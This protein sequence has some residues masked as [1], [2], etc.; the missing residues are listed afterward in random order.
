MPTRTVTRQQTPGRLRKPRHG[1]RSGE[2]AAMWLY[3]ETYARSG[4]SAVDFYARLSPYE[5]GHADRLACE[6]IAAYL[7]HQ[8]AAGAQR[9]RR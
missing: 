5:R 3:G 6:I 1:L 2:V 4:L 7:D 8:R 9:R